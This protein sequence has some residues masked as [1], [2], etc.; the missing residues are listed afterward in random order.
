MGS[1][2]AASIGVKKIRDATS[3]LIPALPEF[4]WMTRMALW[5]KMVIIHNG[6]ASK[7]EAPKDAST[8]LWSTL[9]AAMAHEEP[10]MNMNVMYVVSSRRRLI[11][12]RSILSGFAVDI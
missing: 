4:G 1:M 7:A 12:S 5:T 2:N 10:K 3:C 8:A 11:R 6:M 9:S